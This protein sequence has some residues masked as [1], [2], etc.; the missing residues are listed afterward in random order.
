[1]ILA[2]IAILVVV[3]A[4]YCM[5]ARYL[6]GA[7]ASTGELILAAIPLGGAFFASLVTLG[8][9][10]VPTGAAGITAFVAVV[11]AGAWA[12]VSLWR[13]GDRFII[14]LVAGQPRS[15]AVFFVGVSVAVLLFGALTIVSLAPSEEGSYTV[16]AGAAGDVLYHLAQVT[17]IAFTH[18]WDF[19]EPNFSGEFI[20]YPFFVNLL[21]ALL[22][23]LGTPLALAFH[24]PTLL[25]G[26]AAITLFALFLR[27]LDVSES[28]VLAALF[29]TLFASG[30]GYIA[31]LSGMRELGLLMRHS[32]P[33]PMQA[34]AYPAFL[35]TFLVAQRAFVFGLGLFLLV[36]MGVIRGIGTKTQS[37]FLL[38]G[39]AM[40]FLPLAHTHSFI[41]AGIFCAVVL[42]YLIIWRDDLFLAF[43]RGTLFPAFFLALPQI[44]AFAILP[45]F[46]SV[47]F[48]TFRLGW[49]S[50]PREVL[51]V[52]TAN[53]DAWRFFPWLRF[54]WTNFGVL[55]ALPTFLFSR[56]R[57]LGPHPALAVLG[58]GALA[59]WLVP[60]L[61][62]FHA[63]D[64]NM[65]KLFGY[66][67]LLS[68]A[69]SAIAISLFVGRARMFGVL[70]LWAVVLLSAPSAL[71][72]I[73]YFLRVPQGTALHVFGPDARVMAAW[74]REHTPE[75]AGFISSGFLPVR[76][77]I[78]DDA[79]VFA[80]RKSAL[81]PI[82]WVYTHGIDPTER[83][84]R[85]EDFLKQP[86]RDSEAQKELAAEYLI[87]DDVL[88]NAYP[89][90]DE[91][92][93][94]A[95][96]PLLF[97]AGRLRVIRIE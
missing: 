64:V 51:A 71:I 35:P 94:R 57:H 77:L 32:V 7:F 33:Y 63:W 83:F 9:M 24:A 73:T 72:S 54:M 10:V 19:E 69:G 53:P 3:M 84:E 74:L 14:P 25:L 40:G 13:R 75:N 56:I 76:D 55:L 18:E 70:G 31:Y 17:R 16:G 12:S 26:A 48:L 6:R 50:D 34:I 11:F 37:S 8:M 91:R 39:I 68:F 23:K 78:Q 30:L 95:G 27:R 88:R 4:V 93:G 21:S 1:M 5:L 62:Q 38:A 41:A 97:E 60:N 42:V 15:S 65:N 66:A 87:I 59:L 2:T 58:G 67:I 79:L 28:L 36:L 90:V 49:L 82:V 46:N 96:F 22:L 29:G 20:G 52:R 81:G 43:S 80:G 44:A 61:I 89:G 47:P 92:M 45:R 85:I 86:K